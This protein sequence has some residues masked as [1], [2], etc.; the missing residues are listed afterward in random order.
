M[1]AAS[2]IILGTV[3]FGLHYGINNQKG[4]PSEQEVFEMLDLAAKEGIRI[5]DT[6]DA[7]GNA[8]DIIGKYHA[9]SANR[10]LINTKF[11]VKDQDPVATQL[12][13]A[14]NRL[15][16]ESV[17]TYFFHDFRDM[18]K[19]PEVLHELNE[20]KAQ[21][22]IHSIGVSV[23]DNNEFS[24][25]VETPEIDVVQIPFN[26]LDNAAQRGKLLK[27]AKL[28]NKIIQS[29]SVFLQGLFFREY[30]SYPEKLQPLKNYISS[31]SELIAAAGADMNSIALNYVM[32]QPEID[33]V[34]LGIDTR[35]QL[36]D[37]LESLQRGMPAQLKD[38]IDKIDVKEVELL[39][40]KNWA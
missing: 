6:A 5:L 4:R 2:R 1:N 27:Q 33:Y 10:F 13:R 25:A 29:R 17:H 36:K 31:V 28:K 21:G 8:I 3:Q 30:S 40:P 9:Q 20:L 35:Q 37:N 26:L 18:N 19:Y 32:A 11:H 7:Y 22:L 38:S 39:Y 23:Y 24:Q 14:I 34:I 16:V 12:L 15:E